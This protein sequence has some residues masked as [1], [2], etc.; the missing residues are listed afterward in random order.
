MQWWDVLRKIERQ[1]TL[2]MA[3]DPDDKGP[4]HFLHFMEAVAPCLN[5]FFALCC[6]KRLNDFLDDGCL[7]T[8]KAIAEGVVRI[9]NQWHGPSKEQAQRMDEF[10]RTMARLLTDVES[11]LEELVMWANESMKNPEPAP[12]PE[13]EKTVGQGPVN[14]VT[15][16]SPH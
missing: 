3:M 14:K 6:E 5:A 13:P 2:F 12:E 1:T 10:W 7:A 15:L 11:E 16:N 4:E 8:A 9:A